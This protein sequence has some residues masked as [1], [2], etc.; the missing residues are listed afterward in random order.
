MNS[1]PYFSLAE[2]TSSLSPTFV[3]ELLPFVIRFF[4][5][6]KLTFFLIFT[7]GLKVALCHCFCPFFIIYFPR[8]LVLQQVLNIKFFHELSSAQ[9]WSDF[10]VD[11]ISGKFYLSCTVLFTSTVT[12]K[13]SST[14]T[15][16]FGL[17]GAIK[18]RSELSPFIRKT[19]DSVTK[20]HSVAFATCT[21]YHNTIH[22]VRRKNRISL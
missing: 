20:L 15:V 7:L 9:S 17:C 1:S 5:T 12:N 2:N 4:P 13:D 10:S 14:C 19:R 6:Q 16:S 3:K 11:D 8:N 21:L 22:Y 18:R